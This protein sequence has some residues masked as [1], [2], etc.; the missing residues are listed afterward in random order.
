MAK[1]IVAAHAST[2]HVA[3]GTGAGLLW[4][5][6]GAFFSSICER[7]ALAEDREA[8]VGMFPSLQSSFPHQASTPTERFHFDC[9][10]V[11]VMILS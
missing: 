6:Q 5:C 4:T 3:G 10:Q 7:V 2:A 8:L 9:S 1:T 11:C